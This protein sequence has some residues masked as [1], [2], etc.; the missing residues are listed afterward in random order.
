MPNGQI[1]IKKKPTIKLII[2]AWDLQEE[3]KKIIADTVNF[4]ASDAPLSDDKLADKGFFQFPTV[5]GGVVIV[6]NLMGVQSNE[7]LLDGT[8][9]ADIYLGKVK[10]WNDPAI[11]ALNPE[12]KPPN[13]NIAV[14]RRADGSGTSFVFTQY[15][16][17]V[18]AEWKEKIGVG[19]SVN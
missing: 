11:I 10:K 16:A 12:I 5:I 19:S 1:L 13:Q 6:V 15:L 9:L 17:K 14:V 7:L 18:N 4:G 8:T 3:V 2:K